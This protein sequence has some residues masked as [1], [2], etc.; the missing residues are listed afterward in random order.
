MKPQSAQRISQCTPKEFP[1][2]DITEKIIACA[3]E[4]H[5]IFD[6]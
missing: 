3:I 1:L 4:V 6:T 5:S 2:E